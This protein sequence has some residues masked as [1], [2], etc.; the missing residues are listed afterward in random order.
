MTDVKHLETGEVT[1]A[2]G[3]VVGYRRIGDGPA[4]VILHGAMS[5]GYH[6]MQLA[7]A[8][9]GSFTCY[10]PDRRGRGLSGPRKPGDGLAQDVDDVRA[11]LEATGAVNV[12]G[13]S[14]GAI[15]GLEAA[16]TMPQ[17][18]RLAAFEPPLFSDKRSSAAF[19][20]RLDGELAAGK[21]AAALITG[22]KGAQLGPALFRAMPSRLLVPLINRAMAQEAKKPRGEY[23]PMR[24]LATTLPSDFHLVAE[25]SGAA[26]DFASVPAEVLLMGGSRS[27]AY[28]KATLGDLERV[29]PRHR[30]VELPGV[31]H[32]ASWNADMGG[33]PQ[34]LVPDLLRHFG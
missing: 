7:T 20:A 9:A 27:P 11:L 33:H 8:L 1:S 21:L 2:D 31:G 29:L 34:A 18:S 4:L 28:L 25:K 13:V 30:R 19:V 24:V 3:T 17:I 26:A 10:L 5:S 6:H 15:I 14:S 12:L 23:L 22:M 16:R 32:E